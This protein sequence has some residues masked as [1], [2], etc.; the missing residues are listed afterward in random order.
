M[1]LKFANSSLQYVTLTLCL[2]SR[3]AN[4]YIQFGKILDVRWPSKKFKTTRRFCYLQF[5]SP[6]SIL[7]PLYFQLILAQNLRPT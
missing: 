3:L 5:I 7:A 4:A 6:V 2:S 1:M